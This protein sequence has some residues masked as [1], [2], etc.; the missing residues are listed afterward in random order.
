MSTSFARTVTDTIAEVW[1]LAQAAGI[2]GSTAEAIV[3]SEDIV[4]T[5]LTTGGET[6]DLGNGRSCESTDGEDN[7]LHLDN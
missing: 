6:A 3:K 5:G 2:V 1:V 7:G 4:N